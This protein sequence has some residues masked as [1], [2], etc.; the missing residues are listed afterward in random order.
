MPP[1]PHPGGGG[2]AAALQP[3]AG[4]GPGIAIVGLNITPGSGFA[5]VVPDRLRSRVSGA[6]R[7]VNHGIRPLGSVLGGVL[8]STSGVRPALGAAVVGAPTSLLRAPLAAALADS[9]YP[10]AA[11]GIGHVLTDRQS[12]CGSSGICP[13]N[14]PEPS[15]TASPSR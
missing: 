2:T 7:A 6:H 15:P 10:P 3:A 8:G 1:L 4:F 5:A 12:P 11:C 14:V 13:R 9:R